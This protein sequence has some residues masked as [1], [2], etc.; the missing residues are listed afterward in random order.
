MNQWAKDTGQ[1]ALQGQLEV[2]KKAINKSS[3]EEPGKPFKKRGKEFWNKCV[4][5]FRGKPKD[6]AFDVNAKTKEH[7]SSLKEG[8][9]GFIANALDNVNSFLAEDAPPPN[10]LNNQMTKAAEDI[11]QPGKDKFQQH[12][13][14]HSNQMRASLTNAAVNALPARNP[15]P[16]GK[17]QEVGGMGVR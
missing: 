12:S 14:A 6:I 5:W 11:R 1:Q 15:P 8:K 9:K 7:A 4:S 17:S 13:N 16:Q 2:Q 10:I 3:P